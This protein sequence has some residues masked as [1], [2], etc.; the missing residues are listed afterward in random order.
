MKN[1]YVQLCVLFIAIIGMHTAKF[2]RNSPTKAQVAPSKNVKNIFQVSTADS[3]NTTA[4]NGNLNL[5]VL[6]GLWNMF[7]K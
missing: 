2:M 7:I 3:L 6:P 5:S 4:K 1:G